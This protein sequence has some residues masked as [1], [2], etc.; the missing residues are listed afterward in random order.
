MGGGVTTFY[1]LSKAYGFLQR[2]LA[3]TD[4]A[5]PAD[6]P[7]PEGSELSASGLA[8]ILETTVLQATERLKGSGG[9]S[10]LVRA[11]LADLLDSLGLW[12]SERKVGDFRPAP[13]K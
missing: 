6:L 8:F 9:W 3:L 5:Q 12:D 11:L 2:R 10:Y 1:L 13:I 7:L 4:S